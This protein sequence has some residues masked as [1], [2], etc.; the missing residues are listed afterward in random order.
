MPNLPLLWRGCWTLQTEGSCQAGRENHPTPSPPHCPN[1]PDSSWSK[2]GIHPGKNIGEKAKGDWQLLLFRDCLSLQHL[3]PHLE[4]GWTWAVLKGSSFSCLGLCCPQGML[5]HQ[6]RGRGVPPLC[7]CSHRR[8]YRISNGNL[9]TTAKGI[10]L[11]QQREL[12][13]HSK[14]NLS[15]T[16][17]GID[18]SQQNAVG[19]K[20]GEMHPNPTP[21]PLALYKQLLPSGLDL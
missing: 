16:A 1:H 8:I 13:H 21:V 7:A 14:G 17:K 6:A 11:S 18:P 4:P 19:K 15:I 12:I 10:D 3:L 9:S 20:S 5:W 2:A